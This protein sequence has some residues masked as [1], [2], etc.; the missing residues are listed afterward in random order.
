MGR[1]GTPLSLP[2]AP[3]PAAVFTRRGTGDGLCHL[4]CDAGA[5]ELDPARGGTVPRCRRKGSSAGS[6]GPR[7]ALAWAA[8]MEGWQPGLTAEP[9]FVC[10]MQG[11]G[12]SNG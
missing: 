11:A 10:E 8:G 7:A 12:R 1:P 9:L 4:H 6:G 2:A 3:S 5:R